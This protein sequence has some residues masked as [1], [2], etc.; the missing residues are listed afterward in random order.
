VGCAERGCQGAV[1]GRKTG[2]GGTGG[3]TLVQGGAWGP[4]G[5]TAHTGVLPMT[6][7]KL[8]PCSSYSTRRAVRA[9]KLM[10]PV[11]HAA[12]MSGLV[13]A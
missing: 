9:G 11:D 3:C 10:E 1:G 12:L 4:A 13:S 7:R 2:G 6:Y 8:P 5:T